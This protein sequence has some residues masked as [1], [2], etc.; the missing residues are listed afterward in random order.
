VGLIAHE[1]AHGFV[2]E[3]NEPDLE[4]AA[5]RIASA[6]GF[7]EEILCLAREGHRGT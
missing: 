6:W 2:E 7:S 4:K 5:S 1:L 3:D